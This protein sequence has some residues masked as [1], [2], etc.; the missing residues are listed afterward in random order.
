MRPYA[1]PASART[2]AVL[3]AGA[4]TPVAHAGAPAPHPKPRP[5]SQP[6]VVNV[7]DCGF[8]WGDAGIGSAAGFGGALVLAGSLALAGRIGR[9]A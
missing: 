8:R 6:L 2:L 5:Q 9:P 3:A 1:L 7:E 4:L